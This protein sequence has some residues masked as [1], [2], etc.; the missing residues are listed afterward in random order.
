MAGVVLLSAMNAASDLSGVADFGGEL[1]WQLCVPM[2]IICA[3]ADSFKWATLQISPP[4]Q[5]GT[6]RRSEILEATAADEFEGCMAVVGILA[7]L[8]CAHALAGSKF[9]LP[10]AFNFPTVSIC[11]SK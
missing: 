6:T 3:C 4:W 10:L 2:L 5:G 1:S 9:K 8:V 11:C 7:V